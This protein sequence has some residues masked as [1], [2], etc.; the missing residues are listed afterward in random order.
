MR[1]RRPAISTGRRA[2][3]VGPS[4]G[5]AGRGGSGSARGAGARTGAFRAGGLA[6]GG[7]GF[8]GGAASSTRGRRDFVAAEMMRRAAARATPGVSARASGSGASPPSRS[9]DDPRAADVLALAA[10]RPVKAR[11]PR[12]APEGRARLRFFLRGGTRLRRLPGARGRDQVA[13][14]LGRASDSL[15]AGEGP[16]LRLERPRVGGVELKGSL[17]RGKRFRGAAHP[18][19]EGPSRV[20]ERCAARVLEEPDVVVRQ[21]S[22]LLFA[23][24]LSPELLVDLLLRE[25]GAAVVAPRREQRGDR[26]AEGALVILREH[27]LLRLLSADDQEESKPLLDLRGVPG[28]DPLHPRE[29]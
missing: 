26:P 13:Q 6:R 29:H 1:P 9:R 28:A 2:G 10:S 7:A 21:E 19:E 27:L 17:E 11:L 24:D 23:L 25:D 3:G 16:H 20:V 15:R 8:G 22:L 12:E 18:Q 14:H 5:G 4:F